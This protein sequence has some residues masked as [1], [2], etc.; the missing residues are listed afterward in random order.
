MLRKITQ[1]VTAAEVQDGAG[2]RIRRGIG[3][4]ELPNLDPFLMLDHFGTENPDDYIAGFP[5]HPHRGFVTVTY[6]I[7]GHMQHRDSMGNEGNLGPGDVQWMK[8]ASGVIHSE[9]PQQKDG[10]MRGFQLWLNL[11]ADQKMSSPA[12][13]EFPAA[14]IR[15]IDIKGGQVNVVSGSYGALS[16]P[17]HDANTNVVFMHVDLNA[18]AE[19]WTTVET[20]ATTAIYVF[21]GQITTDDTAVNCHHLIRL[22]GGEQVGLSAGNSGARLLLISG[23]PIGEPI[24]QHGPFVMNTADEIRTAFND[25]HE[26]RLVQERASVND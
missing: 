25:Y 4:N 14:A 11:P 5:D 7:D 13:Q 22:E 6:M 1:I 2:V 20:T 26:G 18:G 8:A 15:K 21:D 9:M 12:Y 3:I 16:G 10:A 19:F 24:A 17:V 23:N